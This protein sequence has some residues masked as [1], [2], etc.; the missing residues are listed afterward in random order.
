MNVADAYEWASARLDG[1]TLM[2]DTQD[3]FEQALADGFFFVQRPAGFDLT[4]GDRFAAHFYLDGR[5]D[6]EYRGF[7]KWNAARLAEREGYFSRE[8]DQV[9]Q[10]FLESRFWDNVFPDALSRQAREMRDFSVAVARSILQRLD[11]PAECLDKATGGILSGRGTYHLTFN[12]FRP[13]V[14]ARGLNIHKDSGWI[15][16]L[17][18]LERG[19]EVLRGEQWLPIVPRQDAFV[20]NFGCAIE[21][22]TKDTR[23]PVAAVAHRV[24]EQQSRPDGAPDRFSYAMFVDSSL[25]TTQCEG[26]YRFDPHVGLV[27]AADFNTFLNRILANTY[28]RDTEGLY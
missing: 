26:L 22:L 24:V 5:G 17:R 25:D 15:T 11:L 14:R 13:Q 12:H 18:S 27:L 16:M 7:G 2:F 6:D 28:D 21:I 1:G 9:E 3:G 20:M 23:T 10:F 19:L 8:A 4:A